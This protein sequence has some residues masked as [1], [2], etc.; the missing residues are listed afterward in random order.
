M[1]GWDFAHVADI[2]I[3]STVLAT[4]KNNTFYVILKLTKYFL[5]E[6]LQKQSNSEYKTVNWSTIA[7][8]CN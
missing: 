3:V 8:A 4:H 1:T 5:R 2:V 7:G 6:T